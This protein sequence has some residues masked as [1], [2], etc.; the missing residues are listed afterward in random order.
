MKLCSECGAELAEDRTCEQYFHDLLAVESQVTGGAGT[1]PHFLAVAT[2]NLQHPSTFMPSVLVDLRRTVSDV[3]AGRAT[4]SDA[5][6][7]ARSANEGPTRVRRRAD[8]SLT[9]AD[10]A[11]LDSWPKKWTMTVRDVCDVSPAL[12]GDRVR[13]WATSVSTQL[14]D[15]A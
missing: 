15:L 3:L 8:T 12:Y 10:R 6:R 14:N 9:E 5:L 11:I 2:Y 4:I 1:E 13:A 7:R